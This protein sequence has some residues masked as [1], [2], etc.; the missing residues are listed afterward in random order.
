M[1]MPMP[2]GALVAQAENP[3]AVA[4]H[5]AA[6]LVKARVG[7]DLPHAVLL[8][9]AEK[10]AAGPAPDLAEALAALAHRRR[11]DDGQQLLGV[12]LDHRVEKRL[13]VVL[14]VAHVAVLEKRSWPAVQN[15][16][17]ALPLVLQGSDMRRKQPMQ[18][19]RVALLFGKG[20]ALVE[21]GVQQ[22][23][24]PVKTGPDDAGVS[25]PGLAFPHSFDSSPCRGSGAD[26]DAECILGL[27]QKV[28]NYPCYAPA[29]SN[30]LLRAS[31]SVVWRIRTSRRA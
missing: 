25:L 16:L 1:G 22:Q 15:P 26:Y 30:Q 27:N 29:A 5:N 3:L 13:A 17:A 2:P 20:R 12:V 21:P 18:G 31:S 7:Q 4:D 23:L 8:R 28:A 14:Q 6:H 24:D 11:I 9:I 19:E 10:Q